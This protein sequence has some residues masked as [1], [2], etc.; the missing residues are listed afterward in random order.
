MQ[1][2]ISFKLSI[3]GII[4]DYRTS[5]KFLIEYSTT[6]M[7][8]LLLS[9]IRLDHRKLKWYLRIK[10]RRKISDITLQLFSIIPLFVIDQAIRWT[11]FLYKLSKESKINFYNISPL[12]HNEWKLGQQHIVTIFF[13]SKLLVGLIP[14]FM[15]N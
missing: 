13:V 9:L 12:M 11:N 8:Y 2:I 4:F 7:K 6:I 3:Y 10:M 14:H 15:Y 5:Y 1:Y